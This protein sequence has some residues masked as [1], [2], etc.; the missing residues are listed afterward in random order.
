MLGS[1]SFVAPLRCA[2]RIRRYKLMRTLSPLQRLPVLSSLRL[3]RG[4][5]RWALT[6]AFYKNPPACCEDDSVLLSPTLGRF[7][8][9]DPVGD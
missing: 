3:I 2:V 4:F 8:S 7:I 6:C 9:T 1:L 5:A